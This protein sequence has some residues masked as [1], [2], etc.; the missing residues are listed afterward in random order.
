MELLDYKAVL[1]L[2]V[3]TW[4]WCIGPR[5]YIYLL[6]L[7]YFRCELFLSMLFLLL[8]F[9]FCGC[10]SV[11]LLGAVFNT[12]CFSNHNY[13]AMCV[14]SCIADYS[15]NLLTNS[16]VN[17]IHTKSATD[18]LQNLKVNKYHSQIP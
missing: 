13:N 9:I 15:V 14:I 8:S 1:C 5:R 6:A 11:S 17:A 7:S 4:E 16:I 3:K 12:F 10:G 18:I 2:R